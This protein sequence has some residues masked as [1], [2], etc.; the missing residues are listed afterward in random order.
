V[1]CGLLHAST[2]LKQAHDRVLAHPDFLDVGSSGE[3]VGAY[4]MYGKLALG[5][6]SLFLD[7]YPLHRFYM[8]RGYKALESSLRYRR[9]IKDKVRWPE[10]AKQRLEFGRPFSEILEGFKAIEDGKIEESV[11]IL[12]RHEQVS[13]LQKSSTTTRIRGWSWMPTSSPGF[14]I[15]VAP[16]RSSSHCQHN[17]NPME[18]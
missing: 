3:A 10:E 13:I 6:L 4:T 18:N 5:N 11:K 8:L 16:P 1:G 7:I 2:T 15:C 14:I 12:A 9:E 17:A